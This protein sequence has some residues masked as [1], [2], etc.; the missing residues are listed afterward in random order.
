ML[1][2]SLET[3]TLF[4]EKQSQEK[5]LILTQQMQ[6]FRK[7]EKTEYWAP[8]AEKIMHFSESIATYIQSI[9][10]NAIVSTY[11]HSLYDSLVNYLNNDLG[12]AVFSLTA[13]KSKGKYN[14]PVTIEFIDEMTGL[15][16]FMS[17]TIPYTVR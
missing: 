11:L 7:R 15:P 10:Q 4:I 6:D 14:V 17:K 13:E 8:C 16:K 9:K 5:L 2:E 3:S 12:I 1:N